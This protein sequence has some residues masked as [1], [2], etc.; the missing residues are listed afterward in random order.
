[1]YNFLRVSLFNTAKKF[2]YVRQIKPM[3]RTKAK[4]NKT[5][6][7]HTHNENKQKNTHETSLFNASD[8]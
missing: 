7:T 2:I 4:H 6:H 5:T 3:G 8:D 1:M